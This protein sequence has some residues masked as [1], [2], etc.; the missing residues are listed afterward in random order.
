MDWMGQ[1]YPRLSFSG[2]GAMDLGPDLAALA[3]LIRERAA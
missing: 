1:G 3:A 2:V